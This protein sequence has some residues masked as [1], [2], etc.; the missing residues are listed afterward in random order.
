MMDD[1]E[2]RQIVPATGSIEEPEDKPYRQEARGRVVAFPFAMGLIG[3]GVLLLAAP[4]I[5]GFEVSPLV[6]GI[7]LVAAF[8]LTNLF[9]FFA[10]GRRERGLYFLALVILSFGMVLAMLVNIPAADAGW[11]PM[12]LVGISLSFFV[13]YI[14]ERQHE[15]GLIAVGLLVMLAAV[16]S[17]LV[18]L[19]VISQDFLDTV[20]DYWPL[21]IAFLGVTLIP[22]AFRQ[23]K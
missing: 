5:E 12:V 10:S 6:A 8:V 2:N 9:R 17:F 21:L 3:L 22:L 23:A 20:Q 1:A 14:F 15:N 16:I 19:E 13:T 18:T 4:E 11:W 7:V